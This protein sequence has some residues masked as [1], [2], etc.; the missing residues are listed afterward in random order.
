MGLG[1]VLGAVTVP[2]WTVDVVQWTV[3]VPRWTVDVAQW[4]VDVA[5]W[6]VDVPRWTIGHWAS[7]GA[8]VGQKS[9]VALWKVANI[10]LVS[11]KG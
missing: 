10:H 1:G 5:R 9:A 7:D 2:R 6:T 3:D 11:E 8:T 4:T